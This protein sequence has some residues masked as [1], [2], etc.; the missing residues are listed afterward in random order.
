MG[1]F[2]RKYC[3]TVLHRDTD[4]LALSWLRARARVRV[5]VCVCACVCACFPTPRWWLVVWRHTVCL[6][7]LYTPIYRVYHV[8][9]GV[10]G[11]GTGLPQFRL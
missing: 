5:C 2:V 7:R 3:S 1:T 11:A 6:F 10:G 4:D 8:C 9:C